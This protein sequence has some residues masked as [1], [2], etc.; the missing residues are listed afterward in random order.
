MSI[1]FACKCLNVRCHLTYEFQTY[2]DFSMIRFGFLRIGKITLFDFKEALKIKSNNNY[3]FHF[4]TQDPEFGI[5][6]EE[7]ANDT[8]LLPGFENKIIS[9][10]EEND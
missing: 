1:I 4:K 3:R 2:F 9:W 10:I 6:K 5:V 7:I 8:T